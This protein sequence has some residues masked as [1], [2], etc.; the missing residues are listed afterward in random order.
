MSSG[1]VLV[2]VSLG[3]CRSSFQVLCSGWDLWIPGI[4]QFKQET[5]IASAFNTEEGGQGIGN[6]GVE[7]QSTTRVHQ[8]SLEN[9]NGRKESLPLGSV[10]VGAE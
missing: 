4:K 6:L 3:T 10:D 8:G 1:N 9:S 5:G 2:Q 7:G